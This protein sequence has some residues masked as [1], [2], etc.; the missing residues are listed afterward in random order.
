MEDIFKSVDT[1]IEDVT[2]II[3]D[4]E[5]INEEINELFDTH[6]L[7]LPEDYITSKG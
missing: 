2:K 7:P 4:Y 5:K 3:K 1:D 6:I